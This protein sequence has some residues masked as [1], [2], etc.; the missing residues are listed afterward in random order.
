MFIYDLDLS[1]SEQLR[2]K[3]LCNKS[4]F[5][6]SFKGDNYPDHV[7]EEKIKAYKPI[8][9]QEV[10]NEYGAIIWI[11]PPNVFVSN[12]SDLFLAKSQKNGLLAWP[13]AQPV[14]QMTHPTMFRYLNSKQ[15]DYF[16][17]HMLDTSQFIIYNN[18]EI[19][20]KLMLPWVKC[21]LKASCIAPPGSKYS[22]CNFTRR[23]FFRYSGCH[24]Y[25]QSAFSIIAAL[26]YKFDESQYT[27]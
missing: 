19:H 22:G 24:R 8:I 26:L 4:C 27:T 17:V 15:R 12:K 5:I 2:I 7:V 16:F 20:Q 1:S 9:I 18:K 13:Q 21:A 23:P 6:R 10:L 11:E 14:S 25:E 3:K